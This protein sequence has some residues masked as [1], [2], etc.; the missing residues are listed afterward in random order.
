MLICA[1]HD[2][3]I[4]WKMTDAVLRVSP[5]VVGEWLTRSRIQ[6]SAPAI[7]SAVLRDFPQSL[8]ATSRIVPSN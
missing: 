8:Q 1:W 7:M 2:G 6:I 4:V 5:N 3:Q